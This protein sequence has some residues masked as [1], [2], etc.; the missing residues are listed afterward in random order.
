[1]TNEKY[2]VSMSLS[3]SKLQ[4]AK[5]EI[6]EVECISEEEIDNESS[7]NIVKTYLVIYMFNTHQDFDSMG[8]VD[9]VEPAS[10]SQQ[11]RQRRQKRETMFAVMKKG[12]FW[13]I[14]EMRKEMQND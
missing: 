14:N 9:V 12:R 13:E 2:R 10:K 6:G 3:S 5:D 11:R 1:M 7:S 8:R 4:I